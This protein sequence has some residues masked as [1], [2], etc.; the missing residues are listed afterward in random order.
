MRLAP[1]LAAIATVWMQPA[2]A[3]DFTLFAVSGTVPVTRTIS[4]LACPPGEFCPDIVSH[5]IVPFGFTDVV[6]ATADG[7]TFTFNEYRPGPR[8]GIFGS[9]RYLGN[10]A[11]EG[12]ELHYV[13]AFLGSTT[14]EM[15]QG[16]TSTFAVRQTFPVPVPEPATWLTL[17]IGLLAVGQ[18]LRQ[19]RRGAEALPLR[20]AIQIG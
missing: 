20:A 12:L 5:E 6:G 10:G 15:A 2:Q 11:Y 13:F 9:F 1:V 3:A 16:Q 7:I 8:E 17:V 14:F 18:A 19:G 4:A